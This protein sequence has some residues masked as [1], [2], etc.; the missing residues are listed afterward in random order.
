M[1]FPI[2]SFLLLFCA[3]VAA[4]MYWVPMS[5]VLRSAAVTGIAALL[6]AVAFFAPRLLRRAFGRRERQPT[7]RALA[8]PSW[9]AGLSRKEME[10]FCGAWLSARGWTVA[11]AT[12]PDPE[13]EGVYVLATRADAPMLAVLCDQRGESLNP[14]D[15]RAF[16]VESGRLGASHAAV[17]TLRPGPL[18]H[19]AVEA[20]R[21]TGV[22]LLRV[23]ELPQTD[24]LI[25][26]PE[27]APVAG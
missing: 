4:I 1:G 15:I 25:R 20:A 9:P 12:D 22:R 24:A 27:P 8:R 26:A 14:A 23:A 6:L 10:T 5:S 17:L 18:P 21:Q 11:L 3:P 2:F 7:A 13:A 19:P 16:A